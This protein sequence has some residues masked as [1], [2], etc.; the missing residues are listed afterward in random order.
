[1]IDYLM[2]CKV[3]YIED[4]PETLEGMSYFLR[5]R[6]GKLY[7]AANVKDAIINFEQ[8]EPDI[9]IVDLLLPDGNGIDIIKSVREK[10]KDC[11][12]FIIT[13]VSAIDTIVDAV[14]QDIEGYILKPID[15]EEL[16]AKLRTGAEKL[17][18]YKKK[19]ED[20]SYARTTS[21][22][23]LLEEAIKKSILDL[24]KKK[25]GRGAKDVKVTLLSSTLEIIVY[26]GLTQMEKTLCTI[27]KNLSSVDQIRNLFYATVQDELEEKISQLTDLHFHIRHIDV[28][29]GRRIDILRFELN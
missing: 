5:K 21:E 11:R 22:S 13:S 18:V 28:D 16:L 2:D 20:T 25:A 1:M 7:V 15:S 27:N 3:L 29:A 6:V 9:M 10:D 14:E 26:D 12:I 4:D 19:R 24:L 17:A 8:H 23:R